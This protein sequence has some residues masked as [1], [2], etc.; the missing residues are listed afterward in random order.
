M[1]TKHYSMFGDEMYKNG[2]MMNHYTPG[3][4]MMKGGMMGSGSNDYKQMM[5]D[6]ATV[7]GYYRDMHKLHTEHQVYHNGIYN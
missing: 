3:M 5:G 2:F 4:G 7:G 1:F 6:T